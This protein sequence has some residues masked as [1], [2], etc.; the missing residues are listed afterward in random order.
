M[1]PAASLLLIGLLCVG[2]SAT[3]PASQAKDDRAEVALQAAIKKET[4]DGDLKAAIEQYGEI[5]RG[6]NRAAAAK[7]L[8]RM[9]RCYEKLGD[10]ES[11]K[12]Y[13]RVLREFGDQQEAADE[14]RARLAAL[15]CGPPGEG[16]GRSRS[17]GAEASG[18]SGIACAFPGW[19]QGRLHSVDARHRADRGPDGSGSGLRHGPA[20][21]QPEAKDCPWP[22][23]GRRMGRASPTRTGRIAGGDPNCF[24]R[25]RHRS[26]Y[27]S[28]RTAGGLVPRRTLHS[29]RAG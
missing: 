22:P 13:E 8:V 14:A 18:H 29:V 19:D 6:G 20:D 10:A 4:V 3:Y 15:G 28:Q 16:E 1:K 2:V 26:G 25:Q 11:R 24:L 21:D 5:A 9:G 12:A 17:H 27:G 7:A 23:S